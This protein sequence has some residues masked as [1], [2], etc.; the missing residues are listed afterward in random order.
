MQYIKEFFLPSWKIFSFNQ[1]FHFNWLIVTISRIKML[2]SVRFMQI[3]TTYFWLHSF[4]DYFWHPDVIRNLTLKL[5]MHDRFST[6]KFRLPKFLS[7]QLKARA[8]FIGAWLIICSLCSKSFV[9]D[10]LSNFYMIRIKL[11]FNK[12]INSI[13]LL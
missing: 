1:R 3:L 4:W 2:Q 13:H 11:G 8:V 5:K 7:D 10:F 6:H 12:N 9:F